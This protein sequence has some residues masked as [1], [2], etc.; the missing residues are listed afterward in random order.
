M[1]LKA[2]AIAARLIVS[3]VLAL[4]ACREMTRSWE[5]RTG[6]VTAECMSICSDGVTQSSELVMT[7]IA[8]PAR[9]NLGSTALAS[10][11]ILR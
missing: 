11:E 3:N 7:L 1:H 9:L 6:N 5:A 8:Q 10:N 2:L 4:V